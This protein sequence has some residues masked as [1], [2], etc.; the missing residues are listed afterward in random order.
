MIFFLGVFLCKALLISCELAPERGGRQAFLPA[1]AG[2]VMREIP[3]SHFLGNPCDGP[4]GLHQQPLGL[5]DSELQ[6]EGH[7]CNPVCS[8]ASR[9]AG[10]YKIPLICFF[11]ACVRAGRRDGREQR[12]TAARARIINTTDPRTELDRASASCSVEG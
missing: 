12:S 6:Q 3:E 2:G 10:F 8:A 9:R 4:R 7:R 11:G 5:L 1:E